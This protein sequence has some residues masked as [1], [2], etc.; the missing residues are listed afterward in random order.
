MSKGW[1]RRALAVALGLG[2]LITV[3][4]AMT[5]GDTSTAAAAMALAGGAWW[6]WPRR[7]ADE[8]IVAELVDEPHLPVVRLENLLK[9]MSRQLA[10]AQKGVY[11]VDALERVALSEM[12]AAK[13]EAGDEAL[14]EMRRLYGWRAPLDAEVVDT[15]GSLAESQ[16]YY[17]A[18]LIRMVMD[19]AKARLTADL[20]DEH[21]WELT[22][23]D[24]TAAPSSGAAG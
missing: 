8:P 13:L 3:K 14:A 15:D 24:L 9:D 11:T 19:L 17:R 18:A 12:K 6:A 21:P 22:D 10:K 5:T 23:A 4:A 2:G 20:R 7:A 1:G 16:A